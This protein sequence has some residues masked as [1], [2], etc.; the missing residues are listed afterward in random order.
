MTML[1]AANIKR[2][3]PVRVSTQSPTV[4]RPPTTPPVPPTAP[5]PVPTPIPAP[6]TPETSA[7][8]APPPQATPVTSIAGVSSTP[9]VASHDLRGQTIQGPTVDRKALAT[10]Y[11]NTWDATSRP[12]FEAD[13]RSVTSNAAA[14]GRLGSGGFRTSLGD[15]T[16]N[17]DIQREGQAKNFYTDAL[18]GSIDDAYKNVGIAQQ[19]QGFQSGQ[20]NQTFGQNLATQQLLDYLTNSQHT[21]DLQDYTVGSSGDPT[22]TYLGLSGLY[23]GQASQG[24]N[25]VGSLIGNT[26]AKNGAQ[27]QA[28]Q[29]AAILKSYG[30]LGGT[31]QETTVPETPAPD[32]GDYGFVG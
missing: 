24:A 26:V 10:D 3:T 1:S 12:Q 13:Q 15:L 28:E 31:G 17:R 14:T 25:N 32:Y 29:L 16:Y 11:L 19:Q 21:R 20:Q 6:T 22:S 23:G 4:T 8:P 7:I 30:I 5:T 2:P 18:N 9:T 27:S